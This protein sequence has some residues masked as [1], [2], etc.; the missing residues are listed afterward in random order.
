MLIVIVL[1]SLVCFGIFCCPPKHK[2]DQHTYPP[3]PSQVLPS[4]KVSSESSELQSSS[5]A[6]DPY[7]EIVEKMG[8]AIARMEVVD[9]ESW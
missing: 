5:E 4:P 2:V 8:R 7:I 1:F 9:P 3:C 6:F